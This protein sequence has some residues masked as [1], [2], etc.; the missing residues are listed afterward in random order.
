MSGCSATARAQRSAAETS[1][2]T[3]RWRIGSSDCL[4]GPERR[5]SHGAPPPAP[6]PLLPLRGGSL[7]PAMDRMVWVLAGIGV[8]NV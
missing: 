5:Q 7:L 3:V 4:G 1:V 8:D 2:G 6:A